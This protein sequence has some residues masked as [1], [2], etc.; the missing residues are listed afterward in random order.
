MFAVPH[1]KYTKALKTRLLL[2]KAAIWLTLIPNIGTSTLTQT[3]LPT[4]MIL[5]LG[6]AN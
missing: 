1:C 3:I 5:L 4:V 2:E 6:F